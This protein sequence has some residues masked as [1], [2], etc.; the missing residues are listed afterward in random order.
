MNGQQ[1]GPLTIKLELNSLLPWILNERYNKFRK[2]KIQIK[3]TPTNRDRYRS[4]Y[5]RLWLILTL[6][7]LNNCLALNP[8]QFFISL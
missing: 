8:N 1:N 5:I 7:Q 4:G 6:T 2:K 3:G